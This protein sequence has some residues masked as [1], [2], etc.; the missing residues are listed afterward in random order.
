[1]ADIDAMLDAAALTRA[2]RDGDR[3]GRDA[4]LAAADTAAVALALAHVVAAIVKLIDSRSDGESLID[5]WQ[6][7]LRSAMAADD[8]DGR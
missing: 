6:A 2:V 5:G 3:E 4:I 7:D 1:M 8:P